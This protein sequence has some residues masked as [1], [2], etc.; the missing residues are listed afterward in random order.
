MTHDEIIQLAFDSGL[1]VIWG[2]PHPDLVKFANLVAAM[3]RAACATM[4]DGCLNI[5]KLGDEIRK[6]K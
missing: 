5:E 1:S 4:A 6:R 3:E 2:Y